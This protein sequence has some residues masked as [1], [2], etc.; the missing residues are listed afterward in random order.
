M[1]L[2]VA[3]TIFGRTWKDFSMQNASQK[4]KKS[5][6]C[7]GW[8][9]T[10]SQT[11]PAVVCWFHAFLCQNCNATLCGRR[12]ILMKI[13][14]GCTVKFG[15][16]GRSYSDVGIYLFVI[17]GDAVPIGWSWHDVGCNFAWQGQ[18]LV[19][20]HCRF[21]LAGANLTLR[22]LTANRITSSNLRTNHMT[23]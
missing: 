19:K 3:G 4:C 7:P 1:S 6:Q 11:C 18:C 20:L 15:G 5:P 22:H 12:N 13:N 23:S 9:L 17:F 10:G 2:F 8:G 14:W 21:F 16:Q